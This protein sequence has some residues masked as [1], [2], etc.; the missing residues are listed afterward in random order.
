M[1]IKAIDKSVLMTHGA[2]SHR[3]SKAKHPLAD[4]ADDD[5]S[6]FVLQET[7]REP[8]R[9]SIIQDLPHLEEANYN[10]YEN[11]NL[12]PYESKVMLQASPLS[13]IESFRALLRQE[14]NQ[15]DFRIM[16]NI[17][18]FRNLINPEITKKGNFSVTGQQKPTET[19]INLSHVQN[20]KILHR[21]DDML[22][23]AT[24]EFLKD[25][26]PTTRDKNSAGPIKAYQRINV[27]PAE[28]RAQLARKIEELH[29]MET[30]QD[31]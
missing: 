21:K 9:K 19:K 6:K 2:D 20:M 25:N 12:S 10:L 17:D 14:S 13:K 11:Q 15:N 7:M 8:L 30:N 31:Y 16:Q 3:S 24:S 26:Y 5:N 28:F 4:I 1:K 29:R 18:N 23:T 27:D 22:H